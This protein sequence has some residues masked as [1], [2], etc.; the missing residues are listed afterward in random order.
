[1]KM[2]V[3]S[4]RCSCAFL[5]PLPPQARASII[6]RGVSNGVAVSNTM[7]TCFPVSSNTAMLG[8]Q[9]CTVNSCTCQIFSGRAVLW[10]Q[11]LRH[12][13]PRS[14]PAALYV[15]AASFPCCG[16]KQCL[17]CPRRYRIAI[18]MAHSSPPH[19]EL[20]R[21]QVDISSR[22][23]QSS[24]SFRLAFIKLFVRRS[25]IYR[26]AQI[27]NTSSFGCVRSAMIL[28]AGQWG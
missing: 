17:I 5:H 13:G 20:T 10:Q 7:P 26:C 25:A 9:F 22:L 23:F 1:M 27:V 12:D 28:L 18:S 19:F 24:L 21:T 14:K 16:S 3:T 2:A 8:S 6:R 15:S 4:K 11:M